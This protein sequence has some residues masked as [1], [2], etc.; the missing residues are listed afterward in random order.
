MVKALAKKPTASAKAILSV[1]TRWRL[2]REHGVEWS[3]GRR[4]EWLDGAFTVFLET[5]SIICLCKCLSP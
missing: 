2:E 1:A 3:E 5:L 4:A